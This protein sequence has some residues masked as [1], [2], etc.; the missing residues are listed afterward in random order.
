MGSGKTTTGSKLA[1]VLNYDFVDM[2]QMIEDGLIDEAKRVLAYRGTPPLKT[3]GYKELFEYFDG[4][5]TK[6]E[7]IQQIKNH[8]RAYARRSEAL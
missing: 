3:V 2:D 4:T 6:E 5:I 8:S 1:R 7:A